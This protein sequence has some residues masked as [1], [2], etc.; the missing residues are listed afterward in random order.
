MGAKSALSGCDAEGKPFSYPE[1]RGR[2]G[3]P[4]RA[5]LRQRP[6]RLRAVAGKQLDV[7]ARVARTWISCGLRSPG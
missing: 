5:E 6:A 3:A 2:V 1:L 7:E 4:R